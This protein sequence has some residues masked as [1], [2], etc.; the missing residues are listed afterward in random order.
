LI[1]LHTHTNE[2]DGTCTPAELVRAAVDA[3]L[4]AL[5]ISDH[6]T[7]AGYE[8][9]VPEAR[10]AGL[11]LI[12]GIELSTKLGSRSVHLLGYFFDPPAPAFCDYLGAMQASRRDRNRRMAERLRSLGLEV[13]LEEV[14]ARGRS[15]TGRPHFASV[16][17]DKG[18]VGSR[19]EAFD[20][21]LDESAI[22][23]VPRLEPTLE[24]GIRRILGAGGI[25]SLAH[26]V[27]LGKAA[28]DQFEQAAREM[29]AAGLIAIEAFHSDHDPKLTGQY[30]EIA[31]RLDL[32][33]TG[34]SDFHGE[35]KPRVRLGSGYNGNLNIPRQVLEDLRRRWWCRNY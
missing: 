12:C 19:Q 31:R 2:S 33:V 4:E 17:L 10:A 8:K 5:G 20:K 21:F 16:L 18:F 34:G 9:A 3:R 11:E 35:A 23:Y 28:G 27:R 32:A 6:D 25:P 14:E 13:T 30:L 26:P 22:A 29:R 7:F 24:E 15:I 1:D